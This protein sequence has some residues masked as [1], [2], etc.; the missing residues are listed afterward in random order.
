MNN[1]T[2]TL[3]PFASGDSAVASIQADVSG[4]QHGLMR[5]SFV[6]KGDIGRLKIPQQAPAL[7]ADRLWEHTCFEAF[8]RVDENPSYCEFN[9]SPSG[10][11]AAYSFRGYRDG[12]AIDDA[13]WSPEIEV[14]RG[15]DRIELDAVV[16]L[17]RS[18]AIQSGSK[19]RIA[20]SAVI[21]AGDGTL[22]YWALKHPS[23]KPDFHHPASFALELAF[24]GQRA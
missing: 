4:N 6:V 19:L 13:G 23:A 12:G 14:R 8:I 5:I 10:E 18:P 22:S 9:F 7:H 1:S 11:W 16:P 24:P 15:S 2:V 21:E 17:D 20:L 3:T